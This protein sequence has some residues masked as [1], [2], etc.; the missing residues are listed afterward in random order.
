MPL[1]KSYSF[2]ILLS[3][4]P[5][6]EARG[7]ETNVLA[8]VGVRRDDDA[9]DDIEADRDEARL[10]LGR[11][12][13][14]DGIGIKKDALRIG[15][16][17]AMLTDVRLSLGRIPDRRHVCIIYAC[18]ESTSIVSSDGPTLQLSRGASPLFVNR[19]V[20]SS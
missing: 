4:V 18:V 16:A 1:V 3:F 5:R 12:G 17:Y 11:V 10:V 14:R 6:G 2:F 19:A 7:Y 9:A 15:E 8:A 20:G 13:D